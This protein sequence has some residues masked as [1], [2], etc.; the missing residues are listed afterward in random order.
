MAQ[1]GND[2][3]CIMVPDMSSPM[4]G[5]NNFPANTTPQ[6]EYRIWVLMESFQSAIKLKEKW[7]FVGRKLRLQAQHF[8]MRWFNIHACR[9]DWGCKM[10]VWRMHCQRYYRKSYW[11]AA[12]GMAMQDLR[13]SDSS[14]SR[15]WM[16]QS[17]HSESWHACS[18]T[19]QCSVFQTHATWASIENQ[20]DFYDAEICLQI[21]R[22]LPFQM[23]CIDWWQA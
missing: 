20:W 21:E 8:C 23:A 11:S 3:T 14:V 15:W 12:I 6:R 10:T 13:E 18:V 22:E 9:Q 17:S 1:S 19:V 4:P 16:T 2:N 5:N 7:M